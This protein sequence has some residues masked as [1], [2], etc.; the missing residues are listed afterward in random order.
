MQ[1]T[2]LT[3][4]RHAFWSSTSNVRTKTTMNVPLL[5]HELGRLGLVSRALSPREVPAVGDWTDKV[6]V[7][8]SSEDDGL[9]QKSYLE[10]M[11]TYLELEG[12]R[13]IPG[14]LLLR[15]HHNK[16][17]MELLR[18][19]WLPEDPLVP[20]THVFGTVE[21][22]ER[23][24]DSIALPAFVKGSAGAGS[25]TVALAQTQEGVVTMARR[26]SRSDGGYGA[27]RKR[28]KEHLRKGFEAESNFRRKFIVQTQIPALDGDFKVLKYGSRFFALRRGNRDGDP[29]ASGA[30]RLDLDVGRYVDLAALLTFAAQVSDR[31]P[32][33]FLSMDI[34][35]SG[36][37]PY[38]IEFQAVYFGPATLE[39][40]QRHWVRGADGSFAEVFGRIGLEEAFAS[41]IAEEL[42][43]R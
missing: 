37:D 35:F 25:A 39:T 31:I 12:A 7:Y 27:A 15:A 22:L 1:V 11:V 38:L 29:R 2:L 26:L 42:S 6:V 14:P 40:S 5:E 17:L 18:R 24:L 16:V 32:S 36:N 28:I 30:G 20:M 33:P 23:D 4:Y 9:H 43:V 34:A 13:L 41:A 10:D 3:D 8:T 21:D 19:H